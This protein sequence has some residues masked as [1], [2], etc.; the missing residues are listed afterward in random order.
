MFICKLLPIDITNEHS[1]S[2][3][4]SVHPN[5][6]DRGSPLDWRS[7][8]G[9]NT[10]SLSVDY[11]ATR[12]SQQYKDYAEMRQTLLTARTTRIINTHKTDLL[13]P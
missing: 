10:K 4:D 8:S 11:R 6:V 7:V 13:R 9:Y 12:T 3:T 2:S 1:C 5:V